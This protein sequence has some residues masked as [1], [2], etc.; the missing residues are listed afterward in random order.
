MKRPTNPLALV[1]FE[2]RRLPAYPRRVA[3]MRT[4]P[5]AWVVAVV[6]LVIVSKV[7]HERWPL[8]VAVAVYAYAVAVDMW[9]RDRL[10]PPC[11]TADHWRGQE[12]PPAELADECAYCRDIPLGELWRGGGHR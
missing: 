9:L 10:D 12:E 8:W 2:D 6:A 3:L 5:T 4:L 7:V 1:Q 11:E